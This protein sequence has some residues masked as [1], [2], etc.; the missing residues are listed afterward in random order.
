MTLYDNLSDPCALESDPTS[1]STGE[2]T[3]GT[4]NTQALDADGDAEMHDNSIDAVVVAPQ[5]RLNL[6]MVKN[7]NPSQLSPPQSLSPLSF[8]ASPSVTTTALPLLANPTNTLTPAQNRYYEE[9]ETH[10]RSSRRRITRS[11]VVKDHAHDSQKTVIHRSQPN[12]E[13]T[14]QDNVDGRSV[15]PCLS[16]GSSQRSSAWHPSSPPGTFQHASDRCGP[17]LTQVDTSDIPLIFPSSHQNVSSSDTQYPPLT[18]QSPEKS[19]SSMQRSAIDSSEPQCIDRRYINSDS[20]ITDQEHSDQR[21]QENHARP[22]DDNAQHTTRS[23]EHSESFHPQRSPEDSVQDFEQPLAHQSVP[24]TT[25]TSTTVS[26][27]SSSPSSLPP[28]SS[29]TSNTLSSI[30]SKPNSTPP[31]PQPPKRTIGPSNSGGTVDLTWYSMSTSKS[32]NMEKAN[33]S[34]ANSASSSSTA[35]AVAAQPAFKVLSARGTPKGPLPI[36][37]QISLLT[38]VLK[39]DPFNCPIRRTTQVWERIS[40][41]QGIR[42]RTCARRYDNII[43]ASIAG[44]DRPVGSEEEIATKKRLLEQLIVMMNQ[45]QALVRMQKKR[46]YRSEEADRKLL[47]ETIRLNPFAQKVGQVARAWEDVRDALGMKVHARQCIRRVNR[48]IKPYQLRE[49]MYNGNIPEEMQEA[50]DDLVKQVMQLMRQSGHGGSLEDDAGQSND[51]DSASGVSDSEEQDYAYTDPEARKRNQVDELEED[52]DEDMPS[53]KRIGHGTDEDHNLAESAAQGGSTANAASSSSKHKT[54]TRR[55]QPQHV[56]YN[57]TDRKN[58]KDR[59]AEY[60]T[61]F[62]PQSI[63]GSHPYS[64]EAV[65]RTAPGPYPQKNRADRIHSSEMVEMHDARTGGDESHQRP[66]KYV[67]SSFGEGSSSHRSASDASY[68]YQQQHSRLPSP[69][70]T[71]PTSASTSSTAQTHG[72]G[73]HRSLDA[74]SQSSSYY[75]PSSP[76]LYQTILSEFHVVKEYLG[77][78]DGQRQRDKENQKAIYS[79]IERLQY[80]VQDQQR[81]IQSLQSQIQYR[82]QRSYAHSPSP[83]HQNRS[84]SHHSHHEQ[85]PSSGYAQPPPFPQNHDDPRDAREHSYHD[86]GPSSGPLLSY[87]HRN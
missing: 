39:H 47:V 8:S 73:R 75:D 62:R 1:T 10:L 56:S 6:D 36:D 81:T 11:S 68:H 61:G 80:Q 42:A 67:D 26:S 77:R 16:S 54:P 48:M 18:P 13:Q 7:S 37:V 43:Q 29:S 20:D 22:I 28:P 24:P 53:P 30:A 46:R 5:T 63:W 3:A 76:Q 64:K 15:T 40:A 85:P 86:G 59:S 35:T 51:D 74:S 17:S 33:E 34:I 65:F 9:Y 57:S 87:E 72:H 38:S 83:Q 44:Q 19:I 82:Q 25:T 78:L 58:S 79:M 66:V 2:G 84:P 71:A 32:H 50:N 21:K 27:S 41:E 55:V 12:T 60:A 49:R 23:R 14:V 52:E 45:P 70:P 4:K 31:Q 69:P